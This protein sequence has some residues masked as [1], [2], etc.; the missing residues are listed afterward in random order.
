MNIKMIKL[1]FGIKLFFCIRF[2]L[3]R[4]ASV[5]TYRLCSKE[6]FCD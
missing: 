5:T 1:C 4:N 6:Q 3:R 2:N